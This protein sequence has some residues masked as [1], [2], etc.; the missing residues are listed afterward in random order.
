M[1]RS[2]S[3]GCRVQS[4]GAASRRSKM[5]QDSRRIIISEEQVASTLDMRGAIEAVERGLAAQAHG[6]AVNM[7]KTHTAWDGSTL[8]AIG[9]VFPKAG[10]AGTKTWAHTPRGASP[11]LILFDAENGAVRAI[12]DDFNLGKQRTA[13]ASGVANRSLASEGV[14]E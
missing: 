13:S 14:V 3:A 7:L 11:L 12:I 10:L 5:G 6:E 1:E 4:G 8:H 9:A 2:V